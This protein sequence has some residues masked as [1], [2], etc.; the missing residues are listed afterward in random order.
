MDYLMQSAKLVQYQ[1]G[2]ASF[3]SILGH[4]SHWMSSKVKHTARG[5]ESWLVALALR[6]TLNVPQLVPAQVGR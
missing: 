3:I 2:Y 6:K 4:Y 5:D 1:L